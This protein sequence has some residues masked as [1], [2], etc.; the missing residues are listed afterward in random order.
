MKLMMQIILMT[1][2]ILIGDSGLHAAKLSNKHRIGLQFGTWH[3][4]SDINKN[5]YIGGYTTATIGTDGFLGGISYGYS[6]TEKNA[7][8][9]EIN[10][11]L[12]NMNFKTTGVTG[13]TETAEVFNILVGVQHYLLNSSM[14]VPVSPFLK[15]CAGAFLGEQ[16]NMDTGTN[17]SL[18]TGTESAFGGQIGVGAD[19]ILGRHF[20]TEISIGY[21]I[22][23][24]FDYSIGGSKNY[25]GPAMSFGLSYGF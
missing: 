18:N 5:N 9:A 21:N 25:S 6:I 14:A 13:K 11:L 20:L 24:D 17:Y 23:S 2:I 4:V 12:A 22:M 10:V 3:Q 16:T 19:F 1:A 15:I 8:R 7:L